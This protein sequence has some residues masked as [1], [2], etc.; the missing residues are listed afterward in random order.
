MSLDVYD[1]CSDEMQKKLTPMRDRFK[2]DEDAKTE[3]KSKVS[4]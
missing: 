1:L 3:L 2:K 4:S